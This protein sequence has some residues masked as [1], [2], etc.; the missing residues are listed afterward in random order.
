MMTQRRT[1]PVALRRLLLTVCWVTA[2][3][4][5]TAC[6]WLEGEFTSLDPLPPSCREPAPDAPPPSLD[7]RP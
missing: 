6:T 1:A 4:A 5:S 3:A 7:G 2:C